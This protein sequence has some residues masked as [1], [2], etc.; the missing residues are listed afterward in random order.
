MEH[1][2]LC[3][4]FVNILFY[5][6]II[7]NKFAE[8]L[9]DIRLEKNISRKTLSKLINVSVRTISYW[10]CGQR[11]CNLEQLCILAKVFNISTDFLLGLED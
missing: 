2:V 5:H 3:Q 11:E 10:E 8:R 1:F 6:I 4:V 9:Q 7:M